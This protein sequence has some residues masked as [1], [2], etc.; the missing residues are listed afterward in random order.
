MML[1]LPGA[2]LQAW[3][4]RRHE[5]R[6]GRLVI[7][8]DGPVKRK[9]RG[10]SISDLMSFCSYMFLAC[11][12]TIEEVYGEKEEDGEYRRVLQCC[13]HSF[14]MRTVFAFYYQY[15]TSNAF[16][17]VC[18]ALMNIYVQASRSS[19][20]G[21]LCFNPQDQENNLISRDVGLSLCHQEV[22]SPRESE[23]YS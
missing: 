15:L 5:R 12:L 17:F 22:I 2:R 9:I 4:G 13:A 21:L 20:L 19:L 7:L 18:S 16:G 23:V 1:R 14:L 10:V 3:P 11:K 8:C 6:R